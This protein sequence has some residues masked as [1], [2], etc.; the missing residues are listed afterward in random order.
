MKLQV[1]FHKKKGGATGGDQRNNK[2]Q[3]RLRGN[4]AAG[5]RGRE[6]PP[7][8]H[9]GA[10]RAAHPSRRRTMHQKPDIPLPYMLCS[11]GP[12]LIEIHNSEVKCIRHSDV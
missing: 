3:L 8:G 1:L 2:L 10:A 11:N 6:R 5:G 9:G 7:A 12:L 4:A